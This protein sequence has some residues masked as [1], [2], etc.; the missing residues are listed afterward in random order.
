MAEQLSARLGKTVNSPWVRKTLQR[1]RDKFADLL[2]EEVARSLQ[3]TEKEALQG[4]LKALELL[5]YCGSAL[6]RRR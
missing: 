4:E 6:E 5:K 3:T 2:V 1:A